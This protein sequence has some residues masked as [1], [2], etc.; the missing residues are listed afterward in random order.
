[1]KEEHDTMTLRAGFAEAGITPPP[2]T[3]KIGW[4]EDL[5]CEKFIDPLSA[6]IAV[7]DNGAARMRARVH[8]SL[9][10]GMRA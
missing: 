9:H 7:F 2:G 4:M 5:R 10:A 3:G 6:R 8:P 1:M